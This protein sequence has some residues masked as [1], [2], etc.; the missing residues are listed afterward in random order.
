MCFIEGFTTGVIVF[1]CI[2]IIAELV[3]KQIAIPKMKDLP[4]M[5]KEQA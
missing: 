1:G 3:S 4:E 5:L 2:L